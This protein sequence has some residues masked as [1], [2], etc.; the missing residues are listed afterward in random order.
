MLP[1][2]LASHHQGLT[3]TSPTG[4]DLTSCIT[5]LSWAELSE[6]GQQWDPMQPVPFLCS[7]RPILFATSSVVRDDATL[8]VR[9]HRTIQERPP[10]TITRIS[11]SHHT[12]T[13]GL[14]GLSADTAPVAIETPPTLNISNMHGRHPVTLLSPSLR[15]TRCSWTQ[16]GPYPT[17]RKVESIRYAGQPW[18][19]DGF[20]P[21]L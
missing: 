1:F 2:K 19:V 9:H 14:S 8:Y 10:T 3:E 12:L 6:G 20:A 15:R 16:T 13:P 17:T 11:I 4:S 7:A 5:R 18:H 21:E